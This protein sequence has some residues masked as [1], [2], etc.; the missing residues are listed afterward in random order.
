MLSLGMLKLVN[1]KLRKISTM[2]T[3]LKQNQAKLPRSSFSSAFAFAAGAGAADAAA[4]EPAGSSI[5]R[6]LSLMAG[7]LL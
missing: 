3:S 1:T 2:M 4:G 5:S 6:M 7:V